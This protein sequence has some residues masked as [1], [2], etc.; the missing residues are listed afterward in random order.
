MPQPS[1]C[2]SAAIFG[3]LGV[4]FWLVVL[5]GCASPPVSPPPVFRGVAQEL[6][7]PDTR[8]LLYRQRETFVPSDETSLAEQ[9]SIMWFQ[10]RGYTVVERS[11]INAALTEQSFSMQTGDDRAVLNAG[12]MLGAQQIVFVMADDK[13]VAFRAIDTETGRILWSGTGVR[14]TVPR[15]PGT[16]E[17]LYHW[18]T[19]GSTRY[20]SRAQPPPAEDRGISILVRQT[21]DTVWASARK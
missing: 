17:A 20:I 5:T 12:R 8:I 15:E 9:E 13:R 14:E 2:D 3:N 21:L 11:R 4:L 7:R 19:R 18:L 10:E 16:W 6:P 1:R